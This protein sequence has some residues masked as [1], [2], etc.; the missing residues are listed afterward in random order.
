MTDLSRAS[1]PDDGI[2]RRTI[3][4][5][6]AWSIP[7]IATAA[8]APVA[9]A[10][11]ALT[12]TFDKAV[13]TGTA[14]STI[15]GAYV[16]VTNG[17]VPVSNAPITVNLT[18]DYTF[19]D[20]TTSF[21]GASD[22]TGRMNV[23]PVKV[24]NNGGTAGI[25][26]S[27]GSSASA[28]TLSAVSNGVSWC[29]PGTATPYVTPKVPTGS[30][31]IGWNVRVSPANDLWVDQTNITA[32]YGMAKVD[33]NNVITAFDNNTSRTTFND[34]AGVSWCVDGT[35]APIQTPNVPVGSKVIGYN[36]RVS[37]TNDLWVDQT[38]ITATYGMAKVD[39][40]N[41]I[42]DLY[43]NTAY[44]TFNDTTGA[45]WLVTGTGTPYK[46][47]K[48]PTG[49][50]VIGWNAR[51]SPTNDLWV[52]QTNITA[53]HGMAK[54]DPDNAFSTL[55]G[56]GSYTTFNDTTG[57]SW[58]VVGTGTP[59]ATPKVPTGS[60]VIG[61][62]VRVSPANDLWVDQTN[63][64]ALNAMAEVDPDNAVAAFYNNNAYVTFNTLTAC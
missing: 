61:W 7:V 50:R 23:A 15:T 8:T 14:C 49:S 10:S 40:D 43:N 26:A 9:A 54:V 33:P 18:G 32:T 5:G 6:A 34:T 59:Y 27:T 60:K 63:I 19:S 16:T 2:A 39:P 46:T 36:V 45:S 20:G 41:A 64:T 55:S 25:L 1:A 48:L 12:L 28:S 52:D 37:P 53:A 56:T 29:L 44:T 3:L 51:I 47:P 57:V 62:N 30:K 31:V 38:N 13:Y 17:G 22:G 21:S 11:A 4:A 24:P 42:A 58:C 35:G